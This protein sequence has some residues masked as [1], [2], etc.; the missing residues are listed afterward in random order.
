MRV[1]ILII[2]FSIIVNTVSL[3]NSIEKELSDKLIQREILIEQCQKET[4]FFVRQAYEYIIFQIDNDICI[5]KKH[6]LW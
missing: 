3:N 4:N 5:L 1:L 2:F 6:K